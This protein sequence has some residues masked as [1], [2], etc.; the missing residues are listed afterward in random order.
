MQILISEYGLSEQL[1]Q[2]SEYKDSRLINGTMRNIT[3]V[4]G[5][6]TITLSNVTP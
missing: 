1:R 6:P 4:G 5:I 2:D 3:H